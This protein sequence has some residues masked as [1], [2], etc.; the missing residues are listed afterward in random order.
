M[1]HGDK[2]DDALDKIGNISITT[3]LGVNL[4]DAFNFVSNAFK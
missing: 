2:T 1:K 3:D 4:K